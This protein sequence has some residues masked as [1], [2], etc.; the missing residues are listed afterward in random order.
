MDMGLDGVDRPAE[1]D[2]ALLVAET[3]D[4][5]ELDG[6]A[7]AVGQRG[8]APAPGRGAGSAGGTLASG[9]VSQPTSRGRLRWLRAR[10]RQ[11]FMVICAS[12][13][14]SWRARMRW[15]S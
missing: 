15:A 7:I 14:R 12:Q 4:V 9:D 6:C 5:A 1:D 13:A 2:C 10:L 3:V 8:K 11:R